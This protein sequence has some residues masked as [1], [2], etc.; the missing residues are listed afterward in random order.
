MK[1]VVLCLSLAA[2]VGLLLGSE[3]KAFTASQAMVTQAAQQAVAHPGHHGHHGHHHG[4]HHGPYRPYRPYRPYGPV[5]VGPP[6]VYYPPYYY[7][8]GGVVIRGRGWG[9]GFGF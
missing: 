7:G 8:P 1:R 2:V 4:W 3:A 5:I 9:I 6:A